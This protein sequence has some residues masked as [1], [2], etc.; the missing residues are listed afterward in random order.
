MTFF[1]GKHHVH[2]QL[3]LFILQHSVAKIPK[4]LFP[5]S[6]KQPFSFYCL[7]K[8]LS[9][10]CKVQILSFTFSSRQTPTT[11]N[12][13]HIVL[14]LLCLYHACTMP[15]LCLLCLYY[16]HYACTMPTM[17]V[18]CLLCLYYA[19]TMPTMPGLCLLCLYYACTVPTM[20]VLCL[21]CLFISTSHWALFAFQQSFGQSQIDLN[22]CYCLIRYLY[23]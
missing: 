2:V 8:Y 18:L 4:H 6:R 17:P 13:R 21:L 5:K 23:H 7:V 22:H 11:K 16:A 1:F 14:C 15:V 19:C 9:M 3:L 20:P 12:H 10:Y